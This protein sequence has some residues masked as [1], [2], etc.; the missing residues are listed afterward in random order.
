MKNK[1]GRSSIEPHSICKEEELENID[2]SEEHEE[3]SLSKKKKIELMSNNQV[4][5]TSKPHYNFANP[6]AD[7]EQLPYQIDVF[8]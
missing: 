6:T 5:R 1:T 8:R 2:E 4:G 3:R 7:L